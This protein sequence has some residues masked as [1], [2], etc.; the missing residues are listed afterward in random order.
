MDV[1]IELTTRKPSFV[2]SS[3]FQLFGSRSSSCLHSCQLES[4]LYLLKTENDLLKQRCKKEGRVATLT[5]E[6]GELVSCVCSVGGCGCVALLIKCEFVL[7][8]L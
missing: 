6:M 4:E 5:E 8:I 7:P 1:L 2:C 3:R